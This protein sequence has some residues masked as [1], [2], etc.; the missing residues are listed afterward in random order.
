MNTDSGD[1]K[2]YEGSTDFGAYSGGSLYDEPMTDYVCNS[3]FGSLNSTT[4][5]NT[6]DCTE[7]TPDF[8][9]RVDS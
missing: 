1:Y 7:H 5:T 2:P 3:G 9:D 6:F 4:V 8:A